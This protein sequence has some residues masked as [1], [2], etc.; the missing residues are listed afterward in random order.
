VN[1]VSPSYAQEILR[2]S[3]PHN[4][5]IGGEG[6]EGVLREAAGKGRLTGILNGCEYPP[7]PKRTTWPAL[8][9]AVAARPDLL[10]PLARMQS[11]PVK[12]PGHVLLS[13][14]RVVGQKVSLMLEP[15]PGYPTALDAVL[16]GLGPRGIFILLGSGEVAL[17][18]ALAQV[19]SRHDNMLF[20]RGYA[21][22]LSEMVY[23]A[24]D[25]FLMPSSFEPCGI[26]QLLA[27]RAGMPCVVHGVGGLSD[28][29]VHG[30]TGFVFHGGMPAVQA[31]AFV[32]TVAQA[33][34]LHS[35]QPAAWKAMCAAAAAERFTWARA[36]RDYMDTV[37]RDGD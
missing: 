24:A 7:R 29:V 31:R 9:K 33:L 18:G 35:D 25:L 1:T 22:V 16:A 27:M 15:V 26:S 3:E 14:G 11:L 20:I 13:V 19:A 32:S 12:R 36:A 17:E 23:S 8:R 30:R 37:Y 5:F 6:L 34:E 2:P 28:T 21:E 4:G 10:E